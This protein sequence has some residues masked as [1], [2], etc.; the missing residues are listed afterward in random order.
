MNVK[1]FLE[2]EKYVAI[3]GQSWR[4]RA[5]KYAI[6]IPL[7]VGMVWWKGWKATGVLFLILLVVALGMHFLFRW[8]TKA[9][10]QS[11]GPYKKLDLPI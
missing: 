8:K 4:F 6:L 9:W 3:H 1:Q 7:F 2:R 5:V 10:T 11:W